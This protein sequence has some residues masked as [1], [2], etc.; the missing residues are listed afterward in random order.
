M[1]IINESYFQSTRLIPNSQELNSTTLTV[2]EQLIDS[3]VRLLLKNALGYELFTDL[4]SNITNGVLNEL[5][6]DKWLNLVNGCTYDIGSDTYK[7]QGLI[8]NE[9][10]VKQSLLADLVYYYYLENEAYK[11]TGIGLVT[12][13]SKNSNNVNYGQSLSMSWNNFLIQYQ[14]SFYD[15]R[16]WYFDFDCFKETN[17]VS[18]LQFLSDNDTDYP[19]APLLTYKLKNEFGI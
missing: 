7:W 10:T 1:Y 13:T 16:N 2:L 11:N 17:Y 8:F 9:G 4:D 18:L 12:V 14:G 19:D 5:A 6:P 3:K 15:Y